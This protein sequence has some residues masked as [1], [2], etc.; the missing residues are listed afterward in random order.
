MRLALLAGICLLLVL[1]VGCSRPSHSAPTPQPDATA[2]YDHAVDEFFDAYFRFNPTQGTASGFHQY[3]TQLEDY[4]RKSVQSQAAF[5]HQYIA[6]FEKIDPARLDQQRRLDRELLLSSL[7][8]TLLELETVRNWERNPDHYSSGITVSAFSI[9]A[10][11]F[12]SQDVRLRSLINREEQ[13]PAVFLAARDN[14][15]KPPKVYTQIA[16]E[17]L[18][19]IV[20][21]FRSD[22]PLAFRQ[23]TDPK[24]LADFNRAN[25]SVIQSLKD[26]E[27]F[28]KT[29]MLPQSTG[30]FRLGAENY[31]K[32]LLYEEMVDTP[33]DHLLAIGY[34]DLRHNQQWFADTAKQIDPAKTPRQLLDSIEQDHPSGAQLLGSFRNTLEGLRTFIQQHNIATI[35]SPVLPIIEETPPFMRALTTASMDTPGPYE[36]VAKEAFFNVTLPESSWPR[37]KVESW[38]RGFYREEITNI[39]VHEAY[40]GHYTQFL[41]VPR[42]PSKVRK[43]IGSNSNAEGWAHYSEQMMVDEGYGRTSSAA[44]P[45]G[46]TA[47]SAISRDIPYLKLRIGQLQDALLRNVRFICGIEMHTRSMTV[48]QCTQMFEKE[49]YQPHAVAEREALRGTSDPTYLVYT[50]GKLAILKLRD[51]YKALRGRD[52]SLQEF[53]DAFLRQGFPPI[54]IIRETML[55][56]PGDI[57]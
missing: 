56:K 11:N 26:Y 19:G 27:A 14:L 9:M 2:A 24:L 28:L 52:F 46:E 42:A 15:K 32:K 8:A 1:P 25:N 7:N 48:E 53:H 34:A 31:R 30:D 20:S 4:S 16:I 51:D 35:P 38:L 54:R 17:Q 41:W 37:T 57:L 47:P 49:A 43:L 39:A 33:L 3:D 44:A 22:V 18:P 12:A 50:L 40:P 45:S 6:R 13:M 29:N 36:S 55:G 23:V 5:A 21:F 10:R